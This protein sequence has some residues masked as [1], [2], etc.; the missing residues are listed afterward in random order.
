M[1]SEVQ[2]KICGIRSLEMAQ[3]CVDEGVDYIGINISPKSKRSVSLSKSIEIITKIQ[4]YNFQIQTVLLAFENKPS[5]IQ[6]VIT[7]SQPHYLQYVTR[8]QTISSEI[9]ESFQIPLLPQIGVH[10]KITDL[11][12]PTTK[13]VIL[14]SF[15]PKE[16]GGTGKSFPWDY[17]TNVKR[18][19]FL[20]GGLEPENVSHAVRKI[21]PFGV[22]VASGVESSPGE[23][24]KSLI[25]KFIKNAKSA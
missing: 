14:D 7:N 19:F 15:H 2:V 17:V 11:D 18:H 23:K 20:A 24:D 16:G 9:W 21:H 1:N 5:D 10:Q 3:F 12:L 25:R 4:N 13:L 8:D 6:E 22:D